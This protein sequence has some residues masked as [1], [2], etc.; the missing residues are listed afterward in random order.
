[1]TDTVIKNKKYVFHKYKIKSF[2]F[3]IAIFIH[4]RLSSC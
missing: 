1:M 4:V 3:L 2:G